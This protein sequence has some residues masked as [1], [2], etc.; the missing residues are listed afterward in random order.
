MSKKATTKEPFL[1]LFMGDFLGSTAEWD[2]EERALYLLLLGYQWTL[3][4]LPSDLK[5]LRKLADYQQENFDRWWP[6]VS[7]KFQVQDDRLVNLRLEEHRAKTQELAQRNSQNGRKGANARWKRDGGA[8]QNERNLDGGAIQKPGKA[9]SGAIQ[10]GAV[11]DGVATHMYSDRHQLANGQTIASPSETNGA[12]QGKGEFGY[13]IHPIPSHPIDIPKGNTH[14]SEVEGGAGG[15]E[16]E[17]APTDPDTRPGRSRGNGRSQPS[18]PRRARRMPK[19]HPTEPFR[20]WA[21]QHTPG[22]DFDHEIAMLK[23]HEF[24]DPHSDWDAV[25]RNWLRRAQQRIRPSTTQ[26]RPRPG[27]SMT[28]ADVMAALDAAVD[29]N[30]EDFE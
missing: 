11:T 28:H 16:L 14:T 5:K 9:D 6:T 18:A 24:R 27:A 1:P 3:G 12:R 17:L 15:R 29:P 23:D 10:S 26:T 25:I 20:E 2:G 21:K 7:Q 8:I 19:D 4:S 13:S 22:V 30:S